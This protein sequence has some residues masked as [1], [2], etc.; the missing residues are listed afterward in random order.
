MFIKTAAK[1]GEAMGFM[2]ISF[3]KN[4]NLERGT[5]A[6]LFGILPFIVIF[7]GS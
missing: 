7:A 2:N 1:I 3:Q 5:V 6:F 4:Q